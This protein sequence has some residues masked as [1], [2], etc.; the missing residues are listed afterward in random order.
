MSNHQQLIYS[1]FLWMVDAIKQKQKM[2]KEIKITGRGRSDEEERDS[3]DCS[4]QALPIEHT[5]A[6][7]KNEAI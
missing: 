4:S 1:V 3:L 7:K 2:R 5:S 6:Q